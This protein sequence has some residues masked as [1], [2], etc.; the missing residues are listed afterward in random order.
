MKVEKISIKIKYGMATIWVGIEKISESLV[1]LVAI[2]LFV[3]YLL[4]LLQK[5]LVYQY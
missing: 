4:W 2:T 3:A 1:R 5:M